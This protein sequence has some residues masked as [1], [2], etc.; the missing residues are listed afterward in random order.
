VKFPGRNALTVAG[1]WLTKKFAS[2]GLVLLYHRVADL[3][4]DPQRLTVKPANFA[5]HLELVK[6]RCRPLPLRDLLRAANEGSLPRRAIGITF[7]DGFADNLLNA[8]PPAEDRQIPVT[9]FVTAGQLGVE[10]EFWWDELE[11]IVLRQCVLPAKLELHVEHRTLCWD[12]GHSNRIS[13][14][15]FESWHVQCGE[16]PTPRHAL[17]RSLCN[18]LR[19]LGDKT[20][21]ELL[22]RLRSWAEVEETHRETHLALT[23]EQLTALDRSECFTI[24]AHTMTHALLSSL[25][26]QEQEAEIY[27]SKTVLEEILGHPVSSF[28]YPF[29]ARGDYDETSV[30]A[31]G[32]AGFELACANFPGVVW[33][34]SDRFQL[35]RL[36][37]RDWDGETFDRWLS[38]W[39]Q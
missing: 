13:P 8:K 10:R 6:S 37:V 23:P 16:D 11:R 24:G 15:L 38:E 1:P 21:R 18:I 27:G 14:D 31:V 29:G 9:V 36:L 20:R 3:P 35:P 2:T 17:Y 33:S 32:S 34:G 7:D 22:D 30:A 28:A 4:S 5:A 19:P 25:S 39:L 12:L 26:A